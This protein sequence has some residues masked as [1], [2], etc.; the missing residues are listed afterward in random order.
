MAATRNLPF[1]LSLTSKRVR[2]AAAAPR[3]LTS[4]LEETAVKIHRRRGVC[5][6]H[7]TIQNVACVWMSDR[8]RAGESVRSVARDYKV[9]EAVVRKAVAFCARFARTS[10]P[11][12]SVTSTIGIPPDIVPRKRPLRLTRLAVERARALPDFD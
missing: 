7:F 11:L 1:P 9:S 4:F 5:H 12:T 8:V 10:T 2:S 6:G 3:D